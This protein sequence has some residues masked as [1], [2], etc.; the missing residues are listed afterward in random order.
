M[1]KESLAAVEVP[2]TTSIRSYIAG[3]TH[4]RR[5]SNQL[6]TR[7]GQRTGTEARSSEYQPHR[8]GSCSH[9]A[10]ARSE[11]QS[12]DRFEAKAKKVHHSSYLSWFLEDVYL[13]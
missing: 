1:V 5:M 3:N 10:R 13:P 9:E 12:M 8:F 7:A 2:S 4:D 11:F 6:R